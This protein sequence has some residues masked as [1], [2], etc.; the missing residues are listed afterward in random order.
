[1]LESAIETK[2]ITWLD[3]ERITGIHED[4]LRQ[5]LADIMLQGQPEPKGSE[6]NPDTLSLAAYRVAE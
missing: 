6:P 1:M 4:E 3:A 5:R 2:T